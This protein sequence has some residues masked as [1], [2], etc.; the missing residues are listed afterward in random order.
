[1][2]GF[3]LFILLTSFLAALLAACNSG[4]GTP[5]ATTG[6]TTAGATTGNTTAGTTTAT[7]TA[8]TTGGVPLTRSISVT[9]NGGFRFE[10]P[11][12]VQSGTTVTWSNQTGAPH[13]IVWTTVT[14]SSS[15]APGSGIATFSP[16][17]NSAPWV[18]PT[19]TT[20]TT[21]HY[22]CGI[23]GPGMAGDIT[24]NP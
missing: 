6:G 3:L 16:G 10:T 17:T 9:T 5:P 1:M 2:K 12:T 20:A 11:V 14:P 8:G 24:V 18:A 23:H 7:T 13:N 19:V 15:P 21:Y 22:F 4:S